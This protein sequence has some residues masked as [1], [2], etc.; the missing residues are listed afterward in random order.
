MLAL[1]KT[2]RDDEAGG[3]SA[4]QGGNP[5]WHAVP[6]IPSMLRTASKVE[7][8]RKGIIGSKVKKSLGI[9]VEQYKEK[10]EP[11]PAALK[12]RKY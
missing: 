4:L 10:K 7:P 8:G 2:L 9:L 11:K 3:R 6:R 1:L 5:N 12:K